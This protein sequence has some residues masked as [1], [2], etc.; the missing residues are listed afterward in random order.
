MEKHW[1]RRNIPD[2][3]LV[4][5]LMS[6][7]KISSV[8][9]SLMAQR[10]IS[11]IA[12]AKAYFNPHPNQLHNPFLMQDMDAAIARIEQA[13]ADNEKILFYGDYDVDGTTSVALMALYFK[14]LYQN[15]ECYVPDRQ[16]EGYGISMQGITYAAE[17]NIRLI[18][19]MDCGIKANEQVEH[20]SKLGIDMIICDHHTPGDEIPKAVAVLDP[21]REDCHY[22]YKELSGCG[23]A[24][25][26]LCALAQN[27]QKL[28][29]DPFKYI[30]LVAVS[31]ASDIVPLTG[32]NRVL[33][34]FGLK[35]LNDQPT[36]GIERLKQTAGYSKE[37]D[38]TDVVF[39]IGPRINAAGRIEHAKKAVELLVGT[40]IEDLEVLGKK[41]NDLNNQRKEIEQTTVEECLRK[42]EAEPLYEKSVTTVIYG[43][44]WH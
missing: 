37:Y 16:T 40:E 13:V 3:G 28:R 12:E 21:K 42:I 5:A 24:F 14:D 27:S 44:D 25:K 23:I 38:I 10:N 2:E 31:I 6:E 32:E 43:E 8:L 41:I 29:N 11:G 39:K 18:I 15:T 19:A 4:D 33:A 36:Q 34:H 9:A 26:V 30:D 1:L 20:A 35:K 22:P 17:Q 7:I